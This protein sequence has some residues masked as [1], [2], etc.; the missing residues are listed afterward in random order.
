[1]FFSSWYPV[2]EILCLPLSPASFLPS[3]GNK[4]SHS[5]LTA[6]PPLLLGRVILLKLHHHTPGPHVVG[7][8]GLANSN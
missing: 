4:I 2:E 3:S 6:N 5:L 1:M 7:V 8:L